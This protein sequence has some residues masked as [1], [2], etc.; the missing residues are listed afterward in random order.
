M[1]GLLVSELKLQRQLDRAWSADLVERIESAIRLAGPQAV[2]QRLRRAAEQGIGQV[3]WIA[4]VGVVQDV[5]N[6]PRK[7]SLRKFH[8]TGNFI[9]RQPLAAVL[10]SGPPQSVACSASEPRKRPLILPI[11]DPGFRRPQFRDLRDGCR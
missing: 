9:V 2:R 6:P 11:A 7:R 8:V 1:A 5:E 4:E 10:D 3:G